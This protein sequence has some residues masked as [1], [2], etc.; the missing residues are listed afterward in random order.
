MKIVFVVCHA[1]LL[2]SYH[3]NTD[4]RKKNNKNPKIFIPLFFKTTVHTLTILLSSSIFHRLIS[5]GTHCSCVS[6]FFVFSFFFL[7]R[8]PVFLYGFTLRFPSSGISY[9]FIVIARTTYTRCIHIV[10]DHIFFFFLHSKS[11]SMAWAR[12]RYSCCN[13]YPMPICT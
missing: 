3:M 1:R 13:I 11:D 12:S 8:Q 2:S 9:A 7:R 5:F 4:E 6:P 10:C